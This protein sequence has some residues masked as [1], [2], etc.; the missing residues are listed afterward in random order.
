MARGYGVRE[1]SRVLPRNHVP[2]SA[3][4]NREI[5]IIPDAWTGAWRRVDRADNQIFRRINSLIGRVRRIS[6]YAASDVCGRHLNSCIS[7]DDL[8]REWRF[9]CR[10]FTTSHKG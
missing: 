7:G 4:W 10:H 2:R 5:F 6:Y 1:G 9:N 8:E 3:W